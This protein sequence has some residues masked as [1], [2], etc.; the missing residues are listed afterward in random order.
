M[1]WRSMPYA[2]R[3]SPRVWQL[4]AEKL[5]AAVAAGRSIEEIRE[6]LVARSAEPLPE[7]VQRLFADTAERSLRLQDRGLARLVECAEP[8]LAALIAAAS[9]CFCRS[10]LK[11]L[12]SASLY[13]AALVIGTNSGVFSL[14][15]NCLRTSA[16]LLRSMIG[17]RN[18]LS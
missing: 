14:G 8:A 13:S 18:S 5:L 9:P 16:F 11:K 15:G 12:A 17:F 3:V 4:Q 7:T 1:A 10:Q 6:F 2:V